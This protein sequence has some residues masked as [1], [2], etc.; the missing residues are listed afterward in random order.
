M[1]RSIKIAL[2]VVAAGVVLAGVLAAVAGLIVWRNTTVTRSAEPEAMQELQRVR[3][4][5]P[6]RRPLVE[7]E[8]PLVLEVSV[9]RPPASAARQR[10][11][12]FHVLAWTGR[13]QKLVRTSAPVWMMRFSLENMA[14]QIGLPAGPLN[15]TVE[16]VERYGPGIV[17]DFSPP[18]GGRVLVWVE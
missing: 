11:E 1:R 7:I 18:G 9:N 16:D 2:W 13:D 3:D 17:L 10:V 14:A 5:F 12:A 15:L 4:R 8:D 6:G